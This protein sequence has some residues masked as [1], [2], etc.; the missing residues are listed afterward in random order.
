MLLH[1]TLSKAEFTAKRQG[2]SFLS[3]QWHAFGQGS[4]EGTLRAL[5]H[6]VVAASKHAVA[7]RLVAVRARRPQAHLPTDSHVRALYIC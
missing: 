4:E 1:R 6:Q 7:L 2:S 5:K 3:T